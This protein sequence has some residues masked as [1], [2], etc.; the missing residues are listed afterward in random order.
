[1]Q[2]MLGLYEFADGP[3]PASPADR[4]PKQFLVEAFRGH[5]PAAGPGARPS[6]F[7]SS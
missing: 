5:R 4:Y 7:P 3:E 6:A 2:F 1:M